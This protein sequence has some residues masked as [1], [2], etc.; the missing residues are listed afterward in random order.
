MKKHFRD[1]KTEPSLILFHCEIKHDAL[2]YVLLQSNSV[3]TYSYSVLIKLVEVRMEIKSYAALSQ[4]SELILYKYQVGT[5]QADEV[6]VD[7]LFCGICHSDISMIE[8][9]WGVSTYPLIAGHEVIGR[10][11]ALG[12]SAQNKGLSIGQ[13]VGIGW[14]AKSCQ[15]CEHCINGKHVNCSQAVPTIINKGGFAE[16]IRADW[17]WVIPLPDKID[18]S[19]AG[20]LL[21]AGITVFKPLLSYNINALSRVGVIGIGGLGHLAIKIVKAMGAEVIA[22]SSSISKKEKIL[23]MGAKKVIN[24]RDYDAIMSLSGK[25][26]LLINTVSIDLNW[27]SYFETLAPQGRFHTLGIVM[28]PFE[29]PSFTLITKDCSV[30]G[31]STGSPGQLRSLLNLSQRA[32]ISPIVKIFPMS[33]INEAIEYLKLGHAFRVVLQADFNK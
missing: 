13:Q 26:D 29:V 27:Q 20:P 33:Q 10:I 30:S 5:L 28:K 17:H 3:V 21:C 9:E 16:K 15:H 2:F 18:A 4:S 14:I 22:F 12:E 1:E 23:N 7:V 32:D 6:E 24:S 19:T 11:T 31:S 8:N 25:L